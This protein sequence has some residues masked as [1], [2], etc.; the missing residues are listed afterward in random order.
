MSKMAKRRRKA[1]K[2]RKTIAKLIELL[3]NFKPRMALP[4]VGTSFKS[5]RDYNRKNN[6]KAVK[7]GLDE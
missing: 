5:I 2:S 1:K 4:P 6:K 3:K 7:D